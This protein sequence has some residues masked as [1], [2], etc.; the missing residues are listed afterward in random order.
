VARC[1]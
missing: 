1:E